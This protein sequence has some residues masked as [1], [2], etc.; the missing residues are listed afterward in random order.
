MALVACKECGKQV[1]DSAATCPQC[2]VVAP[3]FSVR[4]ERFGLPARENNPISV[5]NREVVRS[6]IRAEQDLIGQAIALKINI[7]QVSNSWGEHLAQ[8]TSELSD[9]EHAEFNRLLIEE[10]LRDEGA[11]DAQPGLG[12]G[13]DNHP[14]G[15][16]ETK[17]PSELRIFLAG[18]NLAILIGCALFWLLR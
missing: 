5:V 9:E 11:A 15:L 18:V 12:V 1:S 8:I 3:A 16:N 10:S 6:V 14:A 7:D 17:K 2:G 13:E 4:P